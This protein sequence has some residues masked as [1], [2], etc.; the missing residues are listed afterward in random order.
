MIFECKNCGG[1]VIYNPDKRK[2][3]CPYCDSEDSQERKDYPEHEKDLSLCPNCGG[4]IPVEIHTAASQC[5]YCNNYLIFN[6]RVEGE[7]TPGYVIP[8]QLGKESCKEKIRE[9]FKK[10]IF[11]PTDFLSEA[12]LNTIEGDYV[13]FWMFDYKTTTDFWAEGRKVRSW[14]SGSYRYTE[15]SYYQIHRN[16]GLNFAKVP[17]D[18]STNMPDDVMDLMEPYD[19]S[20]LMAFQP[21]YLSGFMAEKYNLPA[22]EYVNRIKNKIKGDVDEYLKGTY[23]GYA[24]VSPTSCKTEYADEVTN[25][26]FLPVWVY[27]YEYK[28]KEYPFYVNGQTGKIV[29]EVPVS[30]AKVMSYGG[31]MWFVLTMILLFLYLAF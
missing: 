4:E 8:F 14:S 2:M 16:V 11:A 31:T 26:S 28:G 20:Q 12:R 3:C 21:D 29:G 30:K 22:I 27:H 1:N 24:S 23:L 17:A 15:T 18:A 7:N 19:Y 10:C 5:P 13:P 6:S 25:Y 9:K